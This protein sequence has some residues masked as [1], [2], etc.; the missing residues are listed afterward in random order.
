MYLMNSLYL[1]LHIA[2]AKIFHAHMHINLCKINTISTR[3]MRNRRYL[4][5]YQRIIYIHE[6]WDKSQRQR[7]LGTT[8]K[9]IPS[10]ARMCK[11]N[12]TIRNKERKIP[13]FVHRSYSDRARDDKKKYALSC[14]SPADRWQLKIPSRILTAFPVKHSCPSWKSL[15]TKCM[16]LLTSVDR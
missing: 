4:I 3:T 1:D 15:Y 2:Y 16:F 11:K 5:T 14:P 10:P 12:F 8:I 7:Q 6:V 9:K 13:S